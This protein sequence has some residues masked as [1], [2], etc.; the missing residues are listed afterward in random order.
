VSFSC[1]KI[2]RKR[3]KNMNVETCV[4]CI[5][6]KNIMS[7]IDDVK[8]KIDKLESKISTVETKTTIQE[9]QTKQIFEILTDI[10]DSIKTIASK[11]TNLEG[12]PGQ[13]WEEA[14]RTIITVI[15][16]SGVVWLLTK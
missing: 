11:L 7:E 8:I 16:T 10:K 14:T 12:K 13:R 3:G 5:H 9:V 4:D 2:A 1:K 15:V 6:I